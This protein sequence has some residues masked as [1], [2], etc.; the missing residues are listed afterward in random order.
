MN[1]LV[2]A[3]LAHIPQ[4]AKGSPQQTLR[5]IYNMERRRDL[6]CKPPVARSESLR[7]AVEIVR[8]AEG[9]FLPKYDA[10]FF[11]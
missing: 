7:R 3:E 5:L 11:G 9:D 1:H 4:S 10:E 2:A 8:S 6:A